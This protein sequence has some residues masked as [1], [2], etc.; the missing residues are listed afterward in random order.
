MT[1]LDKYFFKPSFYQKL[2]AF[3]LLPFS[4]LY[5]LIAIL[6]T[7]FKKE[8]QFSIPII[9]VGNLTIG[10]NGKTPICKAIAAEFEKN[11]II[12]RGYKRKSKG[13]IVVKH[14]HQILCDISKSG[15]EAMEYALNKECFG[16]IVS[17]DRILGIK[18][19]IE[20]GAK[21]VILDDAFSKFHIKKFDILL[22][23]KEKPY[24][25]FTLPSGAY[26]LPKIYEKKADFITYEGKDFTRYSYVK[27]NQKAILITSIAKP[28]RL[29]EHFIKARACYF[30]A[31]HYAFSK[32]ELETLLK[33]HHCDTLMLTFKDYVKVKDFGF[34]TELIKLEIVLNENFKERLK[35]YVKE[36]N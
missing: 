34:K 23:G 1:W 33:K 29:Y 18:K 11:F 8:V 31:D 21:I 36:F 7:K 5:T 3:L 20:L 15:D 16:V 22:F 32:E 25:N 4:F 6:N 9:S 24:F 17:E 13:L 26:R 27:E 35:A 2:L 28:F 10:G 30:F 19:A 12:L 14:N